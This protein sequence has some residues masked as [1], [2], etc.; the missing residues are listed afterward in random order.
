MKY[1]YVI[2]MVGGGGM[3]EILLVGK[4]QDSILIVYLINWI[5]FFCYKVGNMMVECLEN[6]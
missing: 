6:E 1:S 5:Y 2:W 3:I 4:K